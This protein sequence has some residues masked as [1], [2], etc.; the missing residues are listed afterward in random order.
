MIGVK[1]GTYCN[2]ATKM[3]Q[4]FVLE[5]QC[6]LHMCYMKLHSVDGLAGDEANRFLRHLA[7]SISVKWDYSFSEI[8]G[9]LCACLAFALVRAT[10]V[11]I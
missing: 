2:Y 10:N 6:I 7:H 4:Y 9:W 3:L 11:C 5:L 8:L 1:K